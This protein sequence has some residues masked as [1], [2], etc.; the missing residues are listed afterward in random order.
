MVRFILKW[1]LV[2][3]STT[4]FFATSMA[5]AQQARWRSESG[6]ADAMST[7]DVDRAWS[8]VNA[9]L[10]S[11]GRHGAHDT[12]EC[13]EAFLLEVV[14]AQHLQ[15]RTSGP[16]RERV[17]PLARYVE[18]LDQ[19]YTRCATDAP[20]GAVIDPGRRER[21]ASQLSDLSYAREQAT[22]AAAAPN[23]LDRVFA[24]ELTRITAALAPGVPG[25]W[26]QAQSLHATM[27]LPGPRPPPPPRRRTRSYVP[28]VST[29]VLVLGFGLVSLMTSLA[30]IA[31]EGRIHRRS[32]GGWGL[33]F[34]LIAALPGALAWG[35]PRTRTYILAGSLT[36]LSVVTGVALQFSSNTNRRFL[37]H[38]LLIGSGVNFL[39]TVGARLLYG[40]D[41]SSRRFALGPW[42]PR[43]GAGVS[44]AGRF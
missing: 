44:A 30:G 43:G 23:N 6:L 29:G 8:A 25:A 5:S 26:E 35:E 14:L 39:W 33:T 15:E 42:M 20:P 37:G 4:V 12:L 1:V 34:G 3:A 40:R 9:L 19:A 2:L 7:Q 16:A 38:G 41:P 10:H 31:S 13:M 24:A 28:V 21:L 22:E 36:A 17:A 27:P 11:Q 32:A 18:Q